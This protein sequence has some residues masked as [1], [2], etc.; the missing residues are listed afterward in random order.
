VKYLKRVLIK[1]ATK[2]LLK[3]SKGFTLKNVFQNSLKSGKEFC[4]RNESNFHHILKKNFFK[5][6]V[7][8]FTKN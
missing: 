6:R 5:K 1:K 8:V 4:G 7:S 2:F 3:Y